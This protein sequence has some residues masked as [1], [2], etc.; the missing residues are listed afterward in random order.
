MIPK[1]IF[2]EEYTLAS[3]WAKAVKTVMK[4]GVILPSEYGV[5]TRDVC[6][7]IVVKYP[8]EEPM[9]HP[10]FPTK[11]LHLK[12]YVKQFDRDYDW[13]TQGFTYT[14]MDRFIHYPYAYEDRSW[15][16]GHG[17]LYDCE[18]DQLASLRLQLSKSI[19][20]RAQIITWVPEI[21]DDDDEPPCLQRL[22]MRKLSSTT[23][24]LHCD[25]RSRDLFS[26]WNSNYIA[27]LTMID[28]EI[29][30]P[31]NLKLVKLVDF[32]DAL[33]IYEGNWEEATKV[34]PAVVNPMLMR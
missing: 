25:W 5:K 33:H 26:A 18:L 8:F 23:C 3:A 12:E 13:A 21:D 31:L 10:Q 20:R 28:R 16:E 24:E 27:I 32:V 11:E 30:K 29:L 14:Y 7:T 19:T 1:N 9:L 15:E 6:G 22:W 34:M 4:E 2:I 17:L